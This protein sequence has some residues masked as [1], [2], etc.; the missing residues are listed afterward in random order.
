MDEQVPGESFSVNAPIRQPIV[1]LHYSLMA[2]AFLGSY[3]LAL[4]Y[5]T[6]RHRRY[7]FYTLATGFVIAIVGFIVGGFA[8]MVTTPAN[9]ETLTLIRVILGILGYT[10]LALILGQVALGLYQYRQS[11]EQLQQ[12]KWLWFELDTSSWFGRILPEEN[13]HLAIGWIVLIVGYAY[14]VV[15]AM[16]FTE[17]CSSSS[18]ASGGQ[19]LMP[20]AIGS[21]FLGYGSLVLLHLLNLFS[22]PRSSTPEYYEGLILILWGLVCLIASGTPILGSGWQAINL[23]LLWCAGGIFSVAISLQTW[24]P[25]LRERNIVN[26]L[27]ICLTGRAIISGFTQNDPFSAQIHSVLGHMLIIGSVA[28]I[29][30]IMFRK[31]PAD[32]LPRLMAHASNRNIMENDDN[33]NEDFSD[34]GEE[35]GRTDAYHATLQQ[36]TG[37]SSSNG[38]CKHKWIFASITIICGLLASFLAM[39][40]GILFMGANVQWVGHVR[41]YVND[42][43]TYINATIAVTFLWTTYVFI[44]CTVY[45][46]IRPISISYYEY[47]GMSDMESVSTSNDSNSPSTPQLGETHEMVAQRYEDQRQLNRSRSL[48]ARRGVEEPPSMRPSQ[49]RAKRRSLLIQPPQQQQQQQQQHQHQH[50]LHHDP[51]HVKKQRSRSSSGFSGVGGVLPDDIND[52]DVRR[53]WISNASATSQD[54]ATSFASSVSSPPPLS[55][56]HHIHNHHR[57]TVIF[58]DEPV[59]MMAGE[60]GNNNHNNSNNNNSESNHSNNDISSSN[61][62]TIN[63]RKT[64]SGRR[65]ERVSS[66]KRRRKQEELSQTDDGQL[67]SSSSSDSHSVAKYYSSERN[68]SDSHVC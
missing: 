51:T 20:I 32:N 5:G 58:S 27:I 42:P 19:C 10:L 9:G 23:G 67:S 65:K 59:S 17:S 54:S 68:S 35:T 30:Q 44:M 55:G 41:N 47:L 29:L 22:L 12:Q 48:P 62:K 26:A 36:L 64:E 4:I 18:S 34:D 14:L 6:R 21:G 52:N 11:P 31:S 39:A 60:T 8:Q 53:S 40:V 43:A 7:H 45:R 2:L 63:V 24:M 3:P 50:H 49:Y 15:A 66:S 25:A 57:R 56:D 46:N 13:I 38:S 28:R 61:D 16:V 33:D 37:K 1:I